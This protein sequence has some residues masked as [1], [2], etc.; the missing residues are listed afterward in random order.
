MSGCDLESPHE[1]QEEL[2]EKN[3]NGEAVRKQPPYLIM[4]SHKSVLFVEI[5]KNQPGAEALLIQHEHT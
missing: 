4:W 3:K 1:E 2:I 5:L